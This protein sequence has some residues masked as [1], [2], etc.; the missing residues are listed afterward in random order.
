MQTADRICNF[1]RHYAE[2]AGYWEQTSFLKE[3]S[4]ASG[5]ISFYDSNTGNEL[6][7][8]PKGR[9]FEQ[10]VKESRV[11]GWPS[12][13]DDEVNWDYVRVLPD[14]EAVSVDGT[15]LGH[16]L[17]D[18]NGN[19]RLHQ[20]RERWRG[21]RRSEAGIV[22][23]YRRLCK[24]A[25]AQTRTRR[26]SRWTRVRR[27][28]ARFHAARSPIDLTPRAARAQMP[29]NDDHARFMDLGFEPRRPPPAPKRTF[30]S[31]RRPG[32]SARSGSDVETDETP[33][34]KR[35]PG[36]RRGRRFGP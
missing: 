8:A 5:E 31:R 26:A 4:E 22:H 27:T 6:F 29:M 35:E 17:P 28:R 34:T 23:Q 24:R 33:P 11:H 30:E 7:T 19:R 9:S 20:P 1:N 10:F 32:R 13:R 18:K 16:N 21:G 36:R 14:G 25:A 2:F 12:F 3:E 15:H